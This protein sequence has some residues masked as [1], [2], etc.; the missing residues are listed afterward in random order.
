M[1]VAISND[2]GATWE[3]KLCLFDG[4]ASYPTIALDNS[5]ENEQIHVVFDDGRYYYGQWRTGVEKGTKYEYYGEIYHDVL[6]EDEILAGGDPNADELELLF[7]G[8]SYTDRPW[9]LGFDNALGIYGVDTI[10][11]GGTEVYQWNN[12]EKLAEVV[13]K[14]PKNLFINLGINNIGN[15]GEDGTTVGNQVVAYLEALKAA[16]PNTEIYYNMLV[17]PTTGWH[18]YNAITTS[19]AIVEAYIDGDTTDKVHKIDIRDEI[20]RC[21]E[22]DSAKFNDGLHMSAP[23][24]TILFDAL[25]KEIG[26]GRR[27]E[28]LNIVSCIGKEVS[29][30]EWM[31]WEDCMIES[32]APTRYKVRGYAA[33]DGIYFNAVQYV[34]NLV[35]TGDGWTEQTHLEMEM[36][37][38]NGVGSSSGFVYGSFWMDGNWYLVNS[39][40]VLP[41]GVTLVK[42]NVTVTDRG[43]DY[44]DGYRY[45]VS[46]EVYIQFNNNLE[47]PNDG[48]YAY[49][50]FRHHMPGETTEGFEQSVQE[51]R[52]GNRYLWRDEYS[53]YE[54]RKVGIIRRSP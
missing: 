1:V 20:K 5:T 14:N 45:K 48:P 53:S 2:D 36:W 13:A 25:K 43:A 4:Y 18:D 28:D 47:N 16:L 9:C 7:V 12:E 19:N 34:D 22:A 41:Y 51:H 21:G 37:Q 10:G 29:K 17:Y 8:D 44:E 42:N 46:Y 39:D 54:F 23:G 49:I 50:H 33:D 35:T 26:F 15:A 30:Y 6:T 31:D 27:T 52:D 38:W 3:D 40:G 11:I 32:I 24:Y